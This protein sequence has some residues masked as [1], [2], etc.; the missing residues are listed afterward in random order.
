MD[1]NCKIDFNLTL[2]KV[3]SVLFL[4]LIII[5]DIHK[6]IPGLSQDTL[7]RSSNCVNENNR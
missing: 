5:L 4:I 7:K 6:V 2:C 3:R 1:F